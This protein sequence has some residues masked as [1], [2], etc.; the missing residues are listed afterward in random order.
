[1]SKIFDS[2]AD[3]L[4]DWFPLII[5]FACMAAYWAIT[6]RWEAY[7]RRKNYE[8]LKILN[9]LREKAIITQDEFEEKKESLLNV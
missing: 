2:L 7:S 8:E 5:L 6:S 1:M 3:N 9:D 4:S